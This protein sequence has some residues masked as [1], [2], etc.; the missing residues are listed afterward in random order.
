MAAATT[1]PAAPASREAAD[2]CTC[3]SVVPDGPD[4][5]RAKPVDDEPGIENGAQCSERA[6]CERESDAL[7]ERQPADVS[8]REAGR[9]EDA[10]L[11]QTLLDSK[12][13]EQNDEEK[14]RND[15]EEAEVGE[16]LAEVRRTR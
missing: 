14:R 11:P 12:L 13:E 4:P 7:S 3:R 1:P 9:P 16:V 5:P 15:K 2:T 8:H 10:H 6:S